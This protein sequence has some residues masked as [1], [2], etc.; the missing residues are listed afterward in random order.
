MVAELGLEPNLAVEF[1]CEHFYGPLVGVYLCQ[2]GWRSTPHFMDQGI[3][4]FYKGNKCLY[5]E[6]Y[7]IQRNL[8]GVQSRSCKDTGK[9]H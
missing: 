2:V 9:I 8:I 6:Q 5:I 3:V 4:N 1:F 7:T